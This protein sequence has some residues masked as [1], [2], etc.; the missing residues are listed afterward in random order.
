MEQCRDRHA[1]RRHQRPSPS[2]TPGEEE[3]RLFWTAPDLGGHAGPASYYVVFRPVGATNWFTGPGPIAA[4]TTLLTGLAGGVTYLLGVFAASTDGAFSRTAATTATPTTPPEPARGPGAP[5]N[6]TAVAGDAVANVAWTPPASPGTS[7]IASYLVTAEP[8]GQTCGAVSPD[9]TCQVSGLT[10]GTTYTFTV[11]ALSLAGEGPASDP[12]NP[13]TPAE[14]V[15]PAIVINGSRGSAPDAGRVFVQGL[16]TGLV[17]RQVTP[18]VKLQGETSYQTGVGVRTI[19]AD[20]TFE[21][22]RRTGKK[23]YVYFT[24]GGGI[25]SNRVIIAAQR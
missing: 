1:L 18:R 13:V 10:N 11:R 16:S 7:P 25:R 23:T 5:L 19:S 9:T 24:A 12:S 15:V 17:G 2:A 3:V 6:V 4:R 14:A 22:Q 21:W 20:G 8:G